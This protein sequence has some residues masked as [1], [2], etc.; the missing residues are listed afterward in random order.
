MYDIIGLFPESL[1]SSVESA[2]SCNPNEFS[3][4]PILLWTFIKIRN[5]YTTYQS[6]SILHSIPLWSSILSFSRTGDSGKETN[7]V[8]SYSAL[9]QRS[10][11]A[12]QIL[13]LVIG[14]LQTRRLCAFL[15][16]SPVYQCTHKC[17]TVLSTPTHSPEDIKVNRQ[18]ILAHTPWN[19][20]LAGPN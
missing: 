8:H 17:S 3:S 7:I 11:F 12:P 16:S 5:S 6:W 4:W 19:M 1:N 10:L 9:Q 15:S 20:F 13:T 2:I 18:A 14:T